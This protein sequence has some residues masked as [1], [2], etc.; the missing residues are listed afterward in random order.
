MRINQREL[1][2]VAPPYAFCVLA[3]ALSRLEIILTNLSSIN[4][5]D[6]V[7]PQI[8]QY[9]KGIMR[10]NIIFFFSLEFIFGFLAKINATIYF[11]MMTF[12]YK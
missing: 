8:L 3:S 6:C 12:E 7:F 1:M 9:F 11:P 5:Q 2:Y 4:N 10:N